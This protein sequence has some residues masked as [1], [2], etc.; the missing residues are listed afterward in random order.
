MQNS[1]VHCYLNDRARPIKYKAFD[2]VDELLGMREEEECNLIQK[3]NSM[4]K[5]VLQLKKA[6]YEPF[7]KYQFEMI[8]EV[9]VRFRFKKLR[10]IVL[11]KLSLLKICQSN[12]FTAM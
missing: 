8:K 12:R 11:Y 9:K 5:V 1:S 3:D 7:I 4:A 10:K 2:N 6:G